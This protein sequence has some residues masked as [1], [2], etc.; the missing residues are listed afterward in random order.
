VKARKAE[1]MRVSYHTV[2]QNKGFTWHEPY[3]SLRLGTWHLINVLL[4]SISLVFKYACQ[5]S[6]YD[7]HI[8]RHERTVLP[9]TTKRPY[10]LH[11]I[12]ISLN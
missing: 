5:L 7:E 2:R 4:G 12:S 10:I 9:L 11:D 6:R 3:E 1:V 8:Y